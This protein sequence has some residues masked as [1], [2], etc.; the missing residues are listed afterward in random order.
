MLPSA[1]STTGSR[2]TCRRSPRCCGSRAAGSS[3]ARAARP[4]RRPSAASVPGGRFRVTLQLAN[5]GGSVEVRVTDNGVGLPDGFE[6][7]HS[8][9][10]GLSIVRDL[11]QSQLAGRIDMKSDGGTRVRLL[12]PLSSGD[13]P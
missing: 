6:I 8:N 11:V 12:I 3:P 7:E 5:E 9:R 4:W 13:G 10:L 2:T 1:R